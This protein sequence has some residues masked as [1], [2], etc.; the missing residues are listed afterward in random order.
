MEK[1]SKEL[2]AFVKKLL[3]IIGFVS[4]ILG[5]IGIVVPLLPTTPFLLL[6]AGCFIRGSDRLYQWLMNSKLFGS[7]IRNYREHNAIPLRT[8]ILAIGLLWITILYS[9]IFIVESIYIRIL[10]AA[11]AVAV[12]IHISHFKTLDKRQ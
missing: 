8:K 9:T 3:V 11:I 5:I 1:E 10:L 12:T 4:L 7:Y 2:S 6:S